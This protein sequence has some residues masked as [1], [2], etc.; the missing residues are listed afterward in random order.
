MP[1]RPARPTPPTQGEPRPDETRLCRPSGDRLRLLGDPGDRIALAERLSAAGFGLFDAEA[2]QAEARK[3]ARTLGTMLATPE[4]TPP[5]VFRHALVDLGAAL[6]AD[7]DLL[8]PVARAGWTG[9]PDTNR[10]AVTGYTGHGNMMLQALLRE[11]DRELFGDDAQRQRPA[12]IG[13]LRAEADHHGHVLRAGCVALFEAVAERRGTTLR[14]YVIAPG[15]LAD[16]TARARF[17]DGQTLVLGG[18][19]YAGFLGGDFGA[20]TVWN[21]RAARFFEHH[22]YRRVY[23]VVRDPLAG[24]ASNAAKTVRPLERVLHNREWFLQ[25][26]A[27]SASYLAAVDKHR[28]HFRM[29]RFEDVLKHPVS[30]IRAFAQHAGGE[31]S[32]AQAEAVWG[33]VGLKP[34][35]AAG[36]EHL[37]D[38]L[39]DKRRHFRREHLGLMREAGLSFWF[40]RFRY[41]LPKPDELPDGGLD[42]QHADARGEE[43]K[44]PSTLYGRLDPT[45]LRQLPLPELHAE[46]RATDSALADRAAEAMGQPAFRRVLR[47]LGD[48]FTEGVPCTPDLV[49]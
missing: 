16:A 48:A 38:P 30:S 18:L 3:S 8:H 9:L 10:F 39:A 32:D 33:R 12:W 49:S 5:A 44:T 31:L 42:P 7:H 25:T 14:D 19:P 43:A 23:C 46:V 35:T 2:D 34:V 26:A 17:G 21:D 40:D 41:R 13:R 24:L 15:H 47:S 20:H 45:K 36:A 37:V 1:P 4:G 27:E 29:V 11:V 28:D 6:P 22:G